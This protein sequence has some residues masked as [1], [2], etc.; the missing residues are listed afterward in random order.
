MLIRYI[1]IK[2]RAKDGSFKV[3]LESQKRGI[4]PTKI[5]IAFSV[6]VVHLSKDY[7]CGEK[8]LRDRDG[9]RFADVRCCCGWLPDP[10]RG[11]GH[12]GRPWSPRSRETPQG[13]DQRS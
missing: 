10:F 1:I 3:F 5:S 6:Q 13:L 2:K 9:K 8:A 7:K 4:R 12:G 11:M